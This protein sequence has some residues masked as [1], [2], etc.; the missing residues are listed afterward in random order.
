MTRDKIEYV[1]NTLTLKISTNTKKKVVGQK[2]YNFIKFSVSI[3][4]T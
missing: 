1:L 4:I 2:T 3:K